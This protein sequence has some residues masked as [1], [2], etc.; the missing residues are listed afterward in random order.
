MVSN[1]NHGQAMTK[2]DYDAYVAKTGRRPG[3]QHMNRGGPRGQH[4]VLP[5][6]I[7][8]EVRTGKY[9]VS[10]YADTTVKKVK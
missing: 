1:A 6:R 7:D 10:M 9:N 3:D 8:V 4:H 5:V 2:K